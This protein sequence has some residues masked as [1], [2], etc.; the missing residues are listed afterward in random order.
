MFM[1]VTAECG[2]YVFKQ[3]FIVDHALINFAPREIFIL[4]VCFI[5]Q[6]TPSKTGIFRRKEIT[7]K[8]NKF[9]LFRVDPFP[10]GM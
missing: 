10:E 7:S 4:I 3:T 6:P 9:F 5:A 2:L 1:Y 8:G